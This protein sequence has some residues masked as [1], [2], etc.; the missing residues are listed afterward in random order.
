VQGA[1]TLVRR[2]KTTETCG[3]KSAFQKTLRA[4]AEFEIFQSLEADASVIGEIVSAQRKELDQEIAGLAAE[5]E[6]VA[7][8]AR[9]LAGEV[10]F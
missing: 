2:Q 7:E 8:E 10:P 1:R 6:R 4:I 9:E 5:A 3:L